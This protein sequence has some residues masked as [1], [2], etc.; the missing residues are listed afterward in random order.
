MLSSLCPTFIYLATPT[1]LHAPHHI[2]LPVESAISDINKCVL[3]DE[4]DPE[5][6]LAALTNEFAQLSSVDESCGARYHVALRQ[7]REEKGEDLTQEEIGG[8]I[9]RVNEEVRLEKLGEGGERERNG[10]GDGGGGGENERG[11]ERGSERRRETIQLY[12]TLLNF[13]PQRLKPYIV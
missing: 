1:L 13:D 4:A 5:A 3:G 2:L 11:G 9:E 8:V 12:F 7:A 6:T 10:G